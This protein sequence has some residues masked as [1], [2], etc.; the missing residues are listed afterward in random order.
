MVLLMLTTSIAVLVYFIRHREQAGGRIW[1]TR[2]APALACVGL[3]ASLWLVLS[4]FTLVTGGSAALS[5]VLAAVPFVGLL[6]GYFVGQPDRPA[7]AT[8]P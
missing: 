4:N 6:I 8:A 3:L 1:Q 7:V 5:A 2:I